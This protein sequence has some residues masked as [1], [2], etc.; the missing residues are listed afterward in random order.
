[1]R[2]KGLDLN[3]LAAFAILV[4]ERSVSRAAARLNLSQPAVSAALARLR[5]YF[6]DDL[7]VAQGKRMFPTALAETLRPQVAAVLRTVETMVDA[8]GAF[9]PETSTRTFRVV[10]SDYVLMVLLGPLI[11][12]LDRVAPGVRIAVELPGE[13][14]AGRLEEGRVDLVVTPEEFASPRHPLELAWEEK[15]VVVGWRGNPAFAGPISADDFFA[16]EHL[17][18]ALGTDVAAAFAERQLEQIG[19]PRRIGATVPNFSALPWLLVGTTRIALMHERLARMMEP[20][21]P[22]ALSPVP[23]DFPPMREVLQW[24]RARDADPGL[25]WLRRELLA[26]AGEG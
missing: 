21:L 4:E 20:H 18:V 22:I 19:K 12:R 10:G 2:F 7:L 13:R 6:G 14:T 3:L 17:A 23:F 8:S 11:R 24:H 5:D 25:R 1:M 16:L 9:A 26:V 15:H